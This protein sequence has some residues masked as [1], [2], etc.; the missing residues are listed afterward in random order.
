MFFLKFIKNDEFLF[1]S[2]KRLSLRGTAAEYNKTYIRNIYN[3]YI[4]VEIFSSYLK[5]W[6]GFIDCGTRETQFIH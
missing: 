6:S 3:S 1:G 4:F 2:E 5:N